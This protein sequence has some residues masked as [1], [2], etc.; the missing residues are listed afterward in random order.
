MPETSKEALFRYLVISQ[1]ESLV[2]SGKRK[3][4]AVQKVSGL[5]HLGLDGTPRRVR[6]RTLYRWLAAFE[7]DGLAGL[8]PAKRKLKP[9]PLPVPEKLLDFIAKEKADDPRASIPE[10]IRRAR[11]L[12]IVA[13]D[14]KI[15]RSTV[16]RLLLRRGISVKRRRTANER[17]CRRFAYPHRMMMV[18][19][20]GKHFRAGATR[21]KRV[22]LFY[23]DDATRFGLHVV[24]GASEDKLLFLRG[25]YEMIRRHG[26]ASI[27]YLD[28]GPG[29][30][31]EDTATVL[32]R[33][34]TLLILG[35]AAYPEGHGAIERFNQ[36]AA[37]D[38]L[39][40]L[41]GR[42]DVDPTPGSLELRL[43]HYLFED[44]NHRPHEGLELATPAQRFFA[45]EK[46]LRFP[47]SDAWLRER[48][49]VFLDRRVSNDHVVSVEAVDYER[50]KGHA[51]E[52]T[53]LHLRLL[54]G[55]LH[56]LHQ[57][58][59]M[60]I[61][62]VDLARNALARR[63][64]GG[65]QIQEPPRPL[66]KSAADIAFVQDFFPVVSEDGG[67]IHPPQETTS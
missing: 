43:Q 54:D 48:F 14:L 23:L 32:K 4:D 47:E 27:L 59:L 56:C 33:L 62:P 29:F 20:D 26:L 9:R 6:V 65:D 46:A 55:T 58:R 66:K 50:P 5:P 30:I 31:A 28:R 34:Q 39:R 10:L 21:A 57:G 8:E 7:H 2:L 16:Y 35:E 19:C 12:G 18:L 11:R 38:L 15:H 41:D 53:T 49:V 60:Q 3:K 24:V 44:Y 51:G 42:P 13:Q 61:H 64:R 22:A 37:A 52:R 17:D 67:L 40:G 1:V 45:D 36:T 25:L 63:A